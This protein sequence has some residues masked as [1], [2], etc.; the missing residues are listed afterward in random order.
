MDEICVIQDISE[1]VSFQALCPLSFGKLLSNS[2]TNQHR[3]HWGAAKEEISA[4]TNKFQKRRLWRLIREAPL[5]K[6]Q[7]LFGHCPNGVGGLN[8][9][10]DGLGHLFR[11]E[12]SMFKG[13]F[14]Y[15]WGV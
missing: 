14:S 15:F 10:L 1:H 4:I 3:P 12:L 5:K 13:A 8:A 7:G 2:F 11:E 9:C 6:L